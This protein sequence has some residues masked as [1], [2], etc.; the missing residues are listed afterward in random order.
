MAGIGDAAPRSYVTDELIRR[1]I[2]MHGNKTA[3]SAEVPGIEDLKKWHNTKRPWIRM[4]S[5]A[6]SYDK[7][8]ELSEYKVAQE[9]YG[10]DQGVEDARFNHILWGGKGQFDD[11]LKQVK[12]AHEFDDIYKDPF[13]TGDENSSYRPMPGITALD[14]T[15]AG[16]LGALKKATISFKCYTL[17]DLERLEKLYMYPGLRLLVEWGWS[18]NTA[19]EDA[20]RKSTPISPLELTAENMKST[21]TVY[22]HI[23]RT[24]MESG[25]CYDGLFGTITN[26][27]WSVNK[28][29]SFNCTTKI[30]DFGDSIFTIPVNTPF[31][32]GG[33]GSD[34]KADALTLISALETAKKEFSKTSIGKNN[35]ITE[36]TVEL[37]Q[38]GLFKAKIFKIETGTT[39]KL[40]S[41]KNKQAPKKQL[42]I[43]FGDIVDRLCNRLYA[44]TSD[45]T[46]ENDGKI[47]A[48]AIAMFSIGGSATDQDAGLS[49]AE[50][51]TVVDPADKDKA[52]LLPRQPV[53]VVSNQRNLISVDPDVCLLPNQ[54]GAS[55]TYTVVDDAKSK[56][57]T[58]KYI[59]TGLKG[60]G[61][62]FNVPTKQAGV[63]SS[64]DYERESEYGAG[65][66]ANIF[67]NFD[68]LTQHAA[69]AGTVQDFLGNITKDI[70]TA[71]GDVWMH[72]WRMLD[73]Y[74][75]FMTCV[76]QNFSWSSTI[77][78]L[79]L[80]VDSQSSIVKSLSM[81]SSIST[82]MQNALYMAANGPDTKKDVKIGEM[83]TKNIIPL[84]IEF[85]I[86][87]ISGIQYGTSFAVNYLPHRYRAQ[88]YLFAKQ[89]QHSINNDTWVTTVTTIF[90]WAPVSSALRK[91]QLKEV[92]N[93]LKE[94]TSNIRDSITIDNTEDM[95]TD[96][97]KVYG[98]EKFYPIGIFRSAESENITMGGN[99][100]D[101]IDG[102]PLTAVTEEIKEV[103]DQIANLSI[104]LARTYV[105]GSNAGDVKE[106]T[107]LLKDIIN[108]LPEPAAGGTPAGSVGATEQPP[109]ERVILTPE[110]KSYEV[111]ESEYSTNTDVEPGQ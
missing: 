13:R 75:G 35:A 6:V 53:S 15:Y 105:I 20:D 66:L 48:Q 46:R 64:I 21:A 19:D 65:F 16:T 51:Q 44:L 23:Q 73:E 37:D 90:R 78:A 30:S 29:L 74:P 92:V 40:A 58:S 14:V 87:G 62:D 55:G 31:K 76:D 69:T 94:S 68:R 67:I 72:Q 41:D 108:K 27:T 93:Y 39:S 63:I 101:S 100:N 9:V 17:D 50:I 109:R 97:G 89:V 8:K 32:A 91:I 96:A 22:T 42:Y 106:N 45:S 54:I 28:D 18:V 11:K 80:S 84:Q 49:A 98:N 77:D 36:E 26:F 88:T 85:E 25:G 83:Q 5:N 7:N 107:A 3:T 10:G 56:Y 103:E 102:M 2:G 43:R 47:V 12:L 95:S 79:E 111:T 34:I 4:V 86:D 59:P 52:I 38:V 24:R 33:K 1:T 61:C 57:N 81:Q 110:R 99:S 104:G 60:E 82:N 70:N 71:C